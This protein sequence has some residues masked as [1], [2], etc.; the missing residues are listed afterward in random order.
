M[1]VNVSNFTKLV[2]NQKRRQEYCPTFWLLPSSEAWFPLKKAKAEASGN[3]LVSCLLKLSFTN[4][5]LS[6]AEP[7]EV[8]FTVCWLLSKEVRRV[9]LFLAVDNNQGKKVLDNRI[10]TR[11]VPSWFSVGVFAWLALWCWWMC[12]FFF[13]D[14]LASFF[15]LT[16][17]VIVNIIFFS[18]KTSVG[19][20]TLHFE[21][22]KGVEG[23]IWFQGCVLTSKCWSGPAHI[24]LLGGQSVSPLTSVYVHPGLRPF[25]LNE[26]FRILRHNLHQVRMGRYL[27]LKVKLNEKTNNLMRG[28]LG[29]GSREAHLE[30]CSFTSHS[31]I[32]IFGLVELFSWLFDGES[33]SSKF[34]RELGQTDDRN[35]PQNFSWRRRGR[36]YI[37]GVRRQEFEA[38]ERSWIRLSV[39]GLLRSVDYEVIPADREYFE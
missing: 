34:E 7:P 32:I 18:G 26:R 35:W 13:F 5:Y 22:R 6:S 2:Q 19:S 20:Y 8:A 29:I 31:K 25:T 37:T 11:Q 21:R 16:S 24:E 33:S 39:L 1:N 12:V 4:S 36:Y 28:K 30:S 27:L 15:F 3:I 14:I 10:W 17:G 38:V 23:R 9:I